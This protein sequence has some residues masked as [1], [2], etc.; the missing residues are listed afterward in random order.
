MKVTVEGTPEECEALR[1]VLTGAAKL[2]DK[3]ELEVATIETVIAPQLKIPLVLI[4]GG[5]NKRQQRAI[6]LPKL[7]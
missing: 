5:L 7:P 2:D 1:K 6:E 3:L 4:N